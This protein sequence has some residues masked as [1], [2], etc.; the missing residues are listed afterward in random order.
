MLPSARQRISRRWTSIFARCW[1]VGLLGL[2]AQGAEN[3]VARPLA[4]PVGSKPSSFVF[5]LRPKAFQPTPLMDFNVI[6][7]MTPEGRKLAPPSPEAPVYYVAQVGA[8][9]RTGSTLSNGEKPPPIADLAKAMQR[10][11]ATNGYLAGLPPEHRPSL[12]VVFTFGSHGADYAAEVASAVDKNGNPIEGPAPVTA[13]ELL[14]LVVHDVQL[15]ADM[16][17]RAALIGGKAFAADLKHALVEEV[18]NVQLNYESGQHV[19]A[20]S[21]EFGA[22]I[23][24]FIENNGPLV[25]HLVEEAFHS[26]YFVVASAY[27]YAAIGQGKKLLLWRTKMTVDAQGVNMQETLVPLITSAGPYFGKDMSEVTVV[28]KRISREGHVEIG[29]A[30]VVEDKPAPK[31][32]EAD[33]QQKPKTP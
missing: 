2:V 21:P 10:A 24:T 3:D 29:K 1:L 27:D 31:S 5:S 25:S 30:T 23:H 12:V 18:Q 14:S 20:Q 11:L 4:A 22:P 17:E 28:S 7:E 13:E 26:C 9:V 6:T 33:S 8:F 32:S 15:Q 19:L 16:L